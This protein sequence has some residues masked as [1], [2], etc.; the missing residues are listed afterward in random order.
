MSVD[1]VMDIYRHGRLSLKTHLSGPDV[2]YLQAIESV[3]LAFL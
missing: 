2:D 1:T 3:P